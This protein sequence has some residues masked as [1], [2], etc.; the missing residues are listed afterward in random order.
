MSTKTEIQAHI[1]AKL[2]S[3]GVGILAADHRNVLKDEDDSILQNAYGTVIV[4]THLTSNVFTLKAGIDV[5][6]EIKI[7]KQF[8]SV[9]LS[10]F[11]RCLS[12]YITSFADITNAEFKPIL[13]DPFTIAPFTS[14]NP[15]AYN[16]VG[17]LWTT[18]YNIEQ[19]DSQT[20]GVYRGF[21]DGEISIPSGLINGYTIRFELKYDT[22]L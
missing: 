19:T 15:I 6:Y 4:D 22:E 10:G 8:R 3:G 20:I 18:L 14:G 17:K 1:D 11:V 12:G 7:L 5:E 13:T 21:S 2:P 9:T 16:S